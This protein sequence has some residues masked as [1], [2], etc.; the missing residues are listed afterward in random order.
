MNLEILET[1]QMV[2]L[3]G[4]KRDKNKYR[5]TNF[6]F[7]DLKKPPDILK[8]VETT[9]YISDSLTTCSGKGEKKVK[10]LE[11]KTN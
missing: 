4:R 10:T 8:N 1:N 9:T 11:T 6:K 7:Q 3:T 5:Y 2:L